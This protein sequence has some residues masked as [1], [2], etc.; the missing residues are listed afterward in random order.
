VWSVEVVEGFPFAEL[1]F[2]IDGAFIAE[3][4][5]LSEHLALLAA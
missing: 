3:Q 5:P 4:C 2:E 1:G